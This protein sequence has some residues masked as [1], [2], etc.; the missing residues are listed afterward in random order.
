M[1]RLLE[2]WEAKAD[3]MAWK[4]TEEESVRAQN[5]GFWGKVGHAI[6]PM[7]YVSW[8][9]DKINSRKYN[10]FSKQNIDQVCFNPDFVL[11]K[12]YQAWVTANRL[13]TAENEPNNNNGFYRMLGLRIEQAPFNYVPLVGIDMAAWNND[14]L[15][16]AF[17]AD[18]FLVGLKEMMYFRNMI[19]AATN[20]VKEFT[21]QVSDDMKA[22]KDQLERYENQ[23]NALVAIRDAYRY[24]KDDKN[25]GHALLSDKYVAPIRSRA[26]EDSNHTR[27]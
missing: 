15:V 5:R 24:Y 16:Q 19:G 17:N 13:I 6:N 26:Y 20:S 1:A 2:I 7:T 27:R 10:D 8:V 14:V 4:P 9:G 12:K 23:A 3:Y 22:L 11:I 18:S 25:K 21:K